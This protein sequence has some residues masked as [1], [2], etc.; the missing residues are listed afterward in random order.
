[1]RTKSTNPKKKETL[2]ATLKECR[3]R[4]YF[5]RSD[6]TC[7]AIK[8]NKRKSRRWFAPDTEV[9]PEGMGVDIIFNDNG[10]T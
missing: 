5:K 7:V 9:P 3:R 10:A 2:K 4:G 6:G 8:R 1:M